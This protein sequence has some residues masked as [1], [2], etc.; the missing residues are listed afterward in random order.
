MSISV[1]ILHRQVGKQPSSLDLSKKEISLTQAE[2]RR[3]ELFSFRNGWIQVFSV[4]VT[5]QLPLF[6]S[7]PSS[8]QTQPSTWA[9][10]APLCYF[11]A[12]VS[13]QVPFLFHCSANQPHNFHPETSLDEL[14]L[15]SG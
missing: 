1:I 3:L 11:F 4:T 10:Y 9:I 2:I 8:F 13:Q 5:L 6:S 15:H 12:T 14:V 7:C